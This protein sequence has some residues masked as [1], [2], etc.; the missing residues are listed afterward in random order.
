M[1]WFLTNIRYV[2]W[3]ALAV[4]LLFL[5]YFGVGVAGFAFTDSTYVQAF[6][7]WTHVLFGIMWIGHLYYFNFTQI[8]NMPKIPDEQKPAV[9]KVIAPAAL[10]W[11]R[12]GAMLTLISGV[13]LAW[14]Q[15]YILSALTLGASES[16][17]VPKHIFIGIGMWLAIIMW[18]NVWFIIWP[19]Q[20]KALNI[21]DKYPTLDAAAKAAA[22]KTAMLFSRTNTFLSV[23]MLVA[24]TGASTLF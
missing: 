10:Y 11:F 3:T 13:L 20:Q 2:A 14:N 16:F 15:G 18:F 4:G 12:W 5:I 17:L 8:P 1:A 23:P 24:M 19:N 21:G 9:T 22:G 7:R 6:L